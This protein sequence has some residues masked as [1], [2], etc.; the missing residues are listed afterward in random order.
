MSSKIIS[1]LICLMAALLIFS[2]SKKNAPSE[3][4]RIIAPEDS[5]NIMIFSGG[6]IGS[7]VP[8]TAAIADSICFLKGYEKASAHICNVSKHLVSVTCWK[9]K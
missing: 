2:C 9:P 3:P 5:N 6:Q 1:F 8:C 7:N 4:I